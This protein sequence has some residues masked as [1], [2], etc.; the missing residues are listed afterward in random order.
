MRRGRGRVRSLVVQMELGVEPLLL[1][2]E[3]SQLRWFGL[4]IRTSPRL[5]AMNTDWKTVHC[6]FL[7]G[8]N[9]SP[10][11]RS[12][13]ILRSC[14]WVTGAWDGQAVSSDV[15]ITLGCRGEEGA[16]LEAFDWQKEILDTKGQN[17]FSSGR[18]LSVEVG[19]GAWTSGGSS[20]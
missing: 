11:W 1:C 7:L 15:N 13:S 18:A 17:E 20:E 5:L 10:R 4:S 8:V 2:V 16:E 6:P 14:S 3:R 12:S 19:W 9:C